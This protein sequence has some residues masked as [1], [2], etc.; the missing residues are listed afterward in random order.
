MKT[1]TTTIEPKPG[2]TVTFPTLDI[3]NTVITA[4]STV[5]REKTELFIRGKEYFDRH[6]VES[7]RYT[8]EIDHLREAIAIMEREYTILAPFEV[9]EMKRTAKE[10]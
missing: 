7:L 2:Y 4:L 10:Y 1:Y 8:D 5:K 3:F 6:I 9:D